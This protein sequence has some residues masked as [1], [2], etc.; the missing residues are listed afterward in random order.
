M[1]SWALPEPVLGIEELRGSGRVTLRVHGELDAAGSEPLRDRLDVLRRTY[2]GRLVIDLR[3]V[4]FIASAGV[5][6]LVEADAYARRDGWVLELRQ[7]PPEVRRVFEVSGLLDRL[8][9]TGG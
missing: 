5:A 3:G 6:V 9:F 2:R 4:T 8:P 7:G 1:E